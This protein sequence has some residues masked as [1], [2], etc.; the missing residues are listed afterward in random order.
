MR[1]IATFSVLPLVLFV[2][3]SVS[4]EPNKVQYELQERC[5]KAAAA[6]FKGDNPDGPISNTKDGQS[7]ASYENDYSATLNKCFIVYTIQGLHY[8]S[9]PKHSTTASIL[10]DVNENKEYGAHASPHSGSM[11]SD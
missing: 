2:N 11:I 9:E 10:F 6:A 1:R 8:K 5:G 4:A 7:V 3:G